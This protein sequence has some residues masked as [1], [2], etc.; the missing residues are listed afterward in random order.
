[1]FI[2]EDKIKDYLKTER[3]GREIELHPWLPSTNDR[4]LSLL[5]TGKSLNEGYTV[6]AG[7]QR[8]GRGRQGRPWYSPPGGVYMSVL[9][10]LNLPHEMW[11]GILLVAGIS[12]YDNILSLYK[13]TPTI[14]W[15]N[16]LLI[17]DKKFSGI[18]LETKK[19]GE[20]VYGILGV[21]ID[22][23]VSSDELAI[24]M[25]DTTTS[26]L[27]EMGEMVDINRLIA[28]VINQFEVFYNSF[29]EG[30]FSV[31]DELEA[32]RTIIGRRVEVMSGGETIAGT[33][34]G[35]GENGSVIVDMGGGV[36]REFSEGNLK[37]L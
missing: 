36:R 6:I 5:K 22:A 31:R 13:I 4:L 15:P 16:D 11:N 24:E 12:V 30:S 32:R 14:K 34:L 23:N 26:L 28:E 37:L 25:R 29:K 10:H 2:A 33:V 3:F 1:M 27:I 8:A 21:G 18:L 35:F 19:C 7:E 9:L 17:K 20:D